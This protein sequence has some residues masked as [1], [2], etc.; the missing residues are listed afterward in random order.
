MFWMKQD[1]LNEYRSFCRN[2]LSAYID[3]DGGIVD[4]DLIDCY[5]HNGVVFP[6]E[7]KLSIFSRSHSREGE[8]ARYGAAMQLYTREKS[9]RTLLHR[10]TEPRFTLSYLQGADDLQ[11]YE[12]L[13]DDGRVLWECRCFS[14]AREAL[15]LCINRRYVFEG[16]LSTHK[17]HHRGVG[18]TQIGD[19]YEE[20]GVPLD[21]DLPWL[22]G[23]VSVQWSE[24]GFDDKEQVLQYNCVAEYPYGTV[25]YTLVFGANAPVKAEKAPGMLVLS[26]PWEQRE[27]VRIGFALAHTAEEAIASL[28]DGLSRYEELRDA[29]LEQ[30][31]RSRNEANCVSAD[32]LPFTR[33]YGQAANAALDSLLVGP[34]DSGRIGVRAS[35]GNY[36]FFSLWDAIYPIRDFL[37]N[38]R[39]EE[40]A[41]IVTY[42]MKLPAI[43][44]TPIAALHLLTAWNEAMAFLPDGYMEDLYPY[45]RKIFDFERRLTEPTYRLLLCKGNTGVDHAEQMGLYGMFLSPDVNGLWYNACRAVRN[46]A[47]RHGDSEV[48]EQASEI[49]AGVEIGFRKVFF[50]EQVGY[51]RAGANS[52]LTPAPVDVFH[53]SLTLGY[54]Y[55]AGMYLMRDIC[56]KLAHYQSHQLW[57]PL[58]HRAVAF[59][60][61]LPCDWWRYVHMNQHNGHEMKLQRVAGNMAEVYR[62]MGQVMARSERWK[63]AEETTNFSRF[64]IHPEQVCDWQSFAATAQMEALRSAVV[65]VQRHRGGLCYL[66]AEDRCFVSVENVPL[67]QEKISVSV[68]GEGA[69]AELRHGYFGVVKGT[70]QYPADVQVKDVYFC[71]CEAPSHPVLISALDLP[72]VEVSVEGTSTSV[73]CADTAF[74]PMT[75]YAPSKPCVTVDGVSVDGEWNEEEK[76]L[77]VDRLWKAGERV[78]VSV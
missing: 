44:N 77:Y 15:L 9:G 30:E 11:A 27:C 38:G 40:A 34:M 75:W 3:N 71:R 64:G 24:A 19:H 7:R 1:Q 43:E 41:R 56:G 21:V 74:T 58:G 14:E 17:D 16:T 59:D 25:T 13:M 62:V 45:V 36:G 52:D 8:Y 69:F 49:L 28:R 23:T 37:W 22:N 31:E 51:L 12:M 18:T 68:V 4:L 76:R 5:Y 26:V 6:D 2:E 63:N 47:L 65:G 50:D 54:D 33:E 73:T 66:P 67:G 57:H 61:A 20:A 70:L 29:Q 32:C 55:P 60:S 72:I 53:N 78:T 39:F 42:L 10:P 46:E 48:V 35:A